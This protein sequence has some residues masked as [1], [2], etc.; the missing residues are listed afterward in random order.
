MKTWRNPTP[1]DI[2]AIAPELRP[3]ICATIIGC[4]DDA[5]TAINRTLDMCVFSHIAFDDDKPL[6][7]WGL[8]APAGRIAEWGMPWCMTTPHVDQHR[9][10]FWRQS[11]RFTEFCQG[12]YPRLETFCDARHERSIAWLRR[13]GFEIHPARIIQVGAP[14]FHVATLKGS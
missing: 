12:V 5:M 11:Q 9:K 14:P 6:V 2:A 4:G 7:L 3:E 1:A 8:A 10:W 13:L